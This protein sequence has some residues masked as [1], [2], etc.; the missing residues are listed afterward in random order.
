M[1]IIIIFITTKSSLSIGPKGFICRQGKD[2]PMNNIDS[3]CPKAPEVSP[4]QRYLFICCYVTCWQQSHMGKKGPGSK[5]EIGLALPDVWGDKIKMHLDQLSSSS[6][7][8]IYSVK[9]LIT[10]IT[11]WGCFEE[12]QRTDRLGD[13]ILASLLVK[14]IRNMSLSL[15]LSYS[16]YLSLSLSLSSVIFQL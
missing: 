8:Y 10:I 1:L 14:M 6:P 5:L 4:L 3:T 15:S 9:T 13:S 7:L 11:I 16:L 12:A 2:S